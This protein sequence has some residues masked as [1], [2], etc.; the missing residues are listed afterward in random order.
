VE[1][2]RDGHNTLSKA[3]IMETSR[4]VRCWTAPSFSDG[5]IYIRNNIGDLICINVSK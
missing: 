5:R 2:S 1:A 3:I 4:R